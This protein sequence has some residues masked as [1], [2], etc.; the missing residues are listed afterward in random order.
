M[1]VVIESDN[2]S[3]DNHHGDTAVKSII[4]SLS[5]CDSFLK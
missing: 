5:F 3:M 1:I 4:P 2:D